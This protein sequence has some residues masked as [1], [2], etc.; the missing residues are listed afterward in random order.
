[1]LYLF[2]YVWV[3][4]ICTYLVGLVTGLSEN[5]VIMIIASTLPSV[6]FWGIVW[7]IF[8]EYL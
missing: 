7:Y 5:K 4:L 1:M 8:C 2:F 6:I 3:F